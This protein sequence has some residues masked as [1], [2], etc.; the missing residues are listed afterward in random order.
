MVMELEV[1]SLTD[2][3]SDALRHEIIAGAIGPDQKLSEL[4]IAERFKVST[5]NGVLGFDPWSIG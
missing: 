4:W 5:I 3:L 1:T 2:S